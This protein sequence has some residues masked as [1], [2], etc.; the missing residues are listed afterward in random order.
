M[1]ENPLQVFRRI[2]PWAQAFLEA[3]SYVPKSLRPKSP[4]LHSGNNAPKEHARRVLWASTA[5]LGVLIHECPGSQLEKKAGL[6]RVLLSPQ[7]CQRWP[8]PHNL[9]K[10]WKKKGR[11]KSG[12]QDAESW[13]IKILDQ[14]NG[15]KSGARELLAVF[16]W[17]RQTGVFLAFVF[18]SSTQGCRSLRI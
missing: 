18:V 14:E 11:K 4:Q 15:R 9:S 2:H 8:S 5:T 7:H 1:P 10:T 3:L 13:Q 17:T 6:L 16:L 12:S